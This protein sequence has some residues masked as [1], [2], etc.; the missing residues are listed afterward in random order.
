[1]IRE[2]GVR[3]CYLHGAGLVVYTPAT[4][5]VCLVEE[6]IAGRRLFAVVATLVQVHSQ[7]KGTRICGVR[8][9]QDVRRGGHDIEV[10]GDYPVRPHTVVVALPLDAR[11][12]SHQHLQPRQCRRRRRARLGRRS[13]RR[14]RIVARRQLP[15]ATLIRILNPLAA[16]ARG[17]DDVF[18]TKLKKTRLNF[19]LHHDAVTALHVCVDQRFEQP[20]AAARLPG[21]QVRLSANHKAVQARLVHGGRARGRRRVRERDW[22]RRQ[23]RIKQLSVH[24]NRVDGN[25]VARHR[26]DHRHCQPGDG[27]RTR[28]CRD[29]KWD[30]RRAAAAT[31]RRVSVLVTSRRERRALAI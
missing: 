30:Q 20:V 11:R 8:A 7:R 31:D 26:V 28:A 14:I 4:L 6:S 5:L 16:P 15:S 19:A 25:A 17:I 29:R 9:T 12:R 1:M 10:A 21:C 23:R 13:G 2:V 27:A 24:R 3:T 18:S 22:V